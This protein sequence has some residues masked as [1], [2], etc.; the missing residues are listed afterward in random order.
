MCGAGTAKST[1]GCGRRADRRLSV[2]PGLRAGRIGLQVDGLGRRGR[3]AGP[4][5]APQAFRPDIRQAVANDCLGSIV[6]RHDH[7]W[8]GPASPG[9]VCRSTPDVWRTGW[10]RRRVE[11]LARRRVCV[12]NAASAEL[13][14]ATRAHHRSNR[15]P[16]YGRD[17]S[18]CCPKYSAGP[19]QDRV[20]RRDRRR[21]RLVHTG[22]SRTSGDRLCQS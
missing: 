17:T 22:Q 5:G 7:R 8:T 9:S 1:H 19:G 11:Q 2:E 10:G 6:G 13:V 18:S 3:L 20:G 12:Q 16:E 4:D 21:A 14:A 15:Q